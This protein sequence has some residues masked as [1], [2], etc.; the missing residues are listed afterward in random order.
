M[1]RCRLERGWTRVLE[2][3]GADVAGGVWVQ[4]RVADGWQGHLS[5]L[6]DTWEVRLS[7]ASAH[8]P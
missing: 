3:R 2:G 6:W 5:R 8:C 1:R 7:G 4:T